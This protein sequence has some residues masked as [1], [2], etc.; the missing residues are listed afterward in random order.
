MKIEC[1]ASGS[2]GNCYTIEDGETRLMIEAGISY[3]DICKKLNFKIPSDV[4]ITHSHKD[5]SEAVINLLENAVNVY[6]GLETASE[7]KIEKHHRVNILELEK[8]ISIGSFDVLPL[9]M[10]HDVDCLGFLIHSRKTN[11]RLFFATD[12]WLIDYKINELDY[13]MVEANYDL[14][15][16]ND[17]VN[18][19]ILPSAARNRLMK[20]HMEIESTIKW[21]RLNDLSKVKRIYL[22]HLSSRHSDGDIFKKRVQRATGKPVTVCGMEE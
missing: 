9:N 5:H 8:K 6:T 21:L 20:S 1:L 17:M 16:V 7:L 12:T 3:T 11:E 15:K 10:Y 18:E 19:G 14:D 4:L 2:S 22:M 13:I